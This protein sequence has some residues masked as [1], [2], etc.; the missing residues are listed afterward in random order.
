MAIFNNGNIPANLLY[1]RPWTFSNHITITRP[2]DTTAYAA[3]DIVNNAAASILPVFDFTTYNGIIAG[4]TIRIK[5]IQSYSATARNLTYLIVNSASMGSQTWTDNTAFNPAFADFI[6]PDKAI[7]NFTNDIY[8][9]GITTV[10]DT[11][12]PCTINAQIDVDANNKLYLVLIAVAGFTPASA[13]KFD[14]TIKGE[15]F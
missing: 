13:E 7:V 15:I 4:R 2:A 11:E 5:Q 10:L 12:I 1:T 8:T 14:I 6:V 9:G 3:M